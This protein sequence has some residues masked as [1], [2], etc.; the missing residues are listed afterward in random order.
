[1]RI[2][3]LSDLHNEHDTYRPPAVDADI[4]IL[5][6]DIDVKA[7]GVEWAKKAFL[8]P[9]LYVLGNHEYYS[10]HMPG[11]LEKMRSACLDSHVQVLERDAVIISGT[12]F[13][14][15]TMWTDFSATGNK[16][17][18]SITAQSMMNDYRQI[19]AGEHYRRIKPGDLA[20]EALKT[21]DWLENKL[22]EPFSGQTVVITH[23]APLMRSLAENPHSGGHLDAAY[24]NEWIDLMGEDRVALWV[25][26]HS[27]TPVDYHEAG[28]RIVCNPRG[29]PGE[30]TGFDPQLIINL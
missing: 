8:C 30:R 4:V 25:H 12:R 15:A 19:R 23:H 1:M 10:G 11:T 17:L 27:H 24:A 7:R 20:D 13:L 14:G 21:R 16:P 28:T 26:G 5:A 6:G 9:V 2:H 18:A 29:Y 22:A 3:L